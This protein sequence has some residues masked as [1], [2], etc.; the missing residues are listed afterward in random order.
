MRCGC[1]WSPGFSTPPARGTRSSGRC[2]PTGTPRRSRSPDGLDFQATADAL[3]HRGGQGCWV[4]YS[5]GARLCVRLALDIPRFVDGLVLVSGSPGIADAGEREA[6]RRRRA[7]GERAGA[8][9][10]EVFLGGG[11]TSACSR[12]CPGTRRCSR[13]GGGATRCSGSRISCGRWGRACRSRDRL[14]ELEMPVLVVAGGYDRTYSTIGRRMASAIGP[15]AGRHR[16]PGRA[17]AAP[18]AAAGARSRAA[19]LGEA[20]G[21]PE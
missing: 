3:G 10:V 16:R 8:G 14:G 19:G 13:I 21:L 12:R 17:R 6:R 20:A 1:D 7:S 2:R 5:M 4:G 9:R 11:S 18:R 15:S